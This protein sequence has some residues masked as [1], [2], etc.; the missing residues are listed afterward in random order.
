MRI[1]NNGHIVL[2]RRNLLAL[3]H[4]L[5]KSGSSRTL[6]KS[7]DNGVLIVRAEDDSE[8]YGDKKPGQMTS[9]T[10]NFIASM[11]PHKQAIQAFKGTGGKE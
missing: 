9:D 5:D 8:H 3:L 6:V 2:S 7:C 10:E 4:K 11:T 1:D